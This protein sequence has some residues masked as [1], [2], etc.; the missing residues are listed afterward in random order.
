MYGWESWTTKKAEHRRI[1]AFDLWCWRRLSRVPWMTR[2]SNQLILKE[3][4]PEYSLEGL[5]LKLKSNSLASWYEELTLWKRLWCWERLKVRGEGDDRGWD[6]WMASPTQWTWV[7]VDSRSWWWT[8]RTGVLQYMGLQRVRHDWVT[9]LNLKQMPQEIFFFFFQSV[10][11]FENFVKAL[12]EVNLIFSIILQSFR[13]ATPE[14][15]TWHSFWQ[16]TSTY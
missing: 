13:D 2:R 16:R 5:V 9:G 4:S 10:G 14:N 6:C 7:W 8:L 3:I 11:K 12:Q 15:H 1:D